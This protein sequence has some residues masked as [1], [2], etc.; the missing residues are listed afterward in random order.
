MEYSILS[1]NRMKSELEAFL[2]VLRALY[3]GTSIFS[4]L[5]LITLLT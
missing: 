4:R 1:A 2:G 5:P 3:P